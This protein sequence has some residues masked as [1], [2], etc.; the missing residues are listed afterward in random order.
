MC[1][2]GKLAILQLCSVRLCAACIKA[3]T[4]IATALLLRVAGFA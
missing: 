4:C 3:D 1:E 2:Y